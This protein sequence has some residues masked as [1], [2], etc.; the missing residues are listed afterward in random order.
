MGENNILENVRNFSCGKWNLTEDE[1]AFENWF[2]WL[3]VGIISS[4]IGYIGII[5]NIFIVTICLVSRLTPVL[6]YDLLACLAVFDSVYLITS[7]YQSTA[8]YFMWKGYCSLQAHLFLFLY[9]FRKIVM[10]GSIYTTLLAAWER[11]FAV[12]RPLKHRKYNTGVNPLQMIV[13]YELPVIMFSILYCIPQFFTFQITTRTVTENLDS[14]ENQSIHQTT[15]ETI[16]VH[17]LSYT[18]LRVSRNYVLWYNIVANGIVTGIIPVLLLCF[19]NV[20][21]YVT[22]KHAKGENNK[23]GRKLSVI[24]QDSTANPKSFRQVVLLFG[25]VIVFLI[26]HTLR[27]V[28]NLD[29]LI[30]FEDLTQTEQEAK[31]NNSFC[32]GVQFWTRIT[33]HMSHL[34]LQVSS[35]FNFFIYYYWSSKFRQAFKFQLIR[36]A[37]LCHVYTAESEYAFRTVPPKVA[38]GPR[39][40][41]RSSQLGTKEGHQNMS[42]P[43]NFMS[44]SRHPIEMQRFNEI[45][46][47]TK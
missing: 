41:M 14:P 10:N 47:L 2:G 18:S 35:A 46:T 36:L 3:V 23:C 29:E 4:A 38:L 21:I 39:R 13:K 12:T 34:L 5:L 45:D 8:R 33:D 24:S 40:I 25:V 32:D 11:Y 16:V 17:C 9:P 26:C 31:K 19:L 7:L 42:P 30:T 43:N 1:T 37:T 28:L 44:I 22:V 6:F 20:S 27:L 15:N